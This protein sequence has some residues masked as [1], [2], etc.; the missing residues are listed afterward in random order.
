MAKT[1]LM[2]LKIMLLEEELIFKRKENELKL[3]LLTAE[4]RSKET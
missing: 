3:K 2:Q 4:L 1:K